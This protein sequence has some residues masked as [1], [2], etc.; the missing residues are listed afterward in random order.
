MFSK[1]QVFYSRIYSVIFELGKGLQEM[2]YFTVMLAMLQC[3]SYSWALFVRY[4]HFSCTT[5]KCLPEAAYNLN[6]SKSDN[7]CYRMI[8]DS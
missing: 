2:L 3:C 4:V 8:D 5:S 1:Y 6:S 7:E